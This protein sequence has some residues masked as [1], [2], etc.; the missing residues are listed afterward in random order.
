M[1]DHGVITEPGTIVF[2]RTLPGPIER[3]WAY[4]TESE[5]RGKWFA[6][7]E[8]E[9]KAGGKVEFHFLHKILSHEP[10]PERFKDMENGV[11]FEARVV[12]CD[13]PRRLAYTWPTSNGGDN[14]EVTFELTPQD[15]RVLLV[16][17]HRKLDPDN[18]T[19]TAAGWQSHLGIL[20]DVLN[21]QP[22]R[23]FWTTHAKAEADYKRMIADS[24]H[25]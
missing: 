25:S 9:L 20:E 6:A 16:L 5:K 3:V 2:R 14:S 19:G 7:G 23:G 22:P 1:N 17:T 11:S 8:T 18:M 21:D 24:D 10:T 4:L 12:E 13:P 15:D